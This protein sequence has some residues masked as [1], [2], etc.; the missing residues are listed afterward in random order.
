MA[1]LRAARQAYKDTGRTT[2]AWFIRIERE[3]GTTVRISPTPSNIVMSNRVLK[4][5]S[6]ESLSTPVTYYSA[7]GYTPTAVATQ[8]AL[9]AG[10]FDLEGVLDAVSGMTSISVSE[11]LTPPEIHA[12]SNVHGGSSPIEV[13]VD[14]NTQTGGGSSGAWT[15]LIGATNAAPEWVTFDFKQPG[16]FNRVKVYSNQNYRL[17]ILRSDDGQRYDEVSASKLYL[18]NGLADNSHTIELPYDLRSRYAMLRLGSRAIAVFEVEFY[19][20]R[21]SSSTGSINRADLENNLYDNAKVFMFLTDYT[22]PYEDDEKMSSGYLTNIEL[23][24]GTYMAQYRD[25]ISTLDHRVGRKRTAS[26]DVA[27][28]SFPCGVHLRPPTWSGEM[29][30]YAVPDRDAALGTWIKPSVD[31]GYDYFCAEAGI[32]GVSEPTWGTVGGGTTVDGDIS[33]VAT[34]A[35]VITTTVTSIFDDRIMGFAGI[36]ADGDAW[37][38]GTCEF[39]TGPLAGKKVSV[40]TQVVDL[41]RFAQTLSNQ[42]EVGDEVELTQGCLKRFNVDCK[43]KYANG[44]NFQGS[45]YIPGA[46]IISKFGGQ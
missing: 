36:S 26:C 29:Y 7:S 38:G 46:K 20:D 39:K 35:K 28:G 31:N 24:D 22:N 6:V 33:W 27:L 13:I 5:G 11:K 18:T 2:D 10:T 41:L 44:T 1:T 37:R 23:R 16:I 14:G 15:S 8:D 25:K 40:T 21:V 12:V 32:A 17:A 9:R 4:D 34:R 3:D 45:L 43:D 30:A 42:P 19:H